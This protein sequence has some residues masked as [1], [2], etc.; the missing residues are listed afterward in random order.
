MNPTFAK[1][2]RW[3]P[4]VL[5]LLMALYTGTSIFAFSAFGEG[6]PF[7]QALVNL[8]I[9]LAFPTLV[10]LLAVLLG[11]RWPL[12][13]AIIFLALAFVYWAPWGGLNVMPQYI[14]V[15]CIPAF[16]G[17]LFLADWW[18]RRR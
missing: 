9:G 16:I 13:G 17:L 10:L 18:I 3:S 11:W 1:T 15:I 14:P 4:R 7:G 6:I 8:I 2:I 12:V 5:G